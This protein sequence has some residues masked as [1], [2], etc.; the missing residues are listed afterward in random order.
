[1]HWKPPD[2]S[3]PTWRPDDPRIGHLLGRAIRGP[4]E[5]HAVLIGFPSDEGC[6]RTLSAID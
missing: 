2:I 4:E 6:G 3:L 1:M 5:A